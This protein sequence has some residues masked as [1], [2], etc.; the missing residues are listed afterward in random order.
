MAYLHDDMSW[1]GKFIHR[2]SF[3]NKYLNKMQKEKKTIFSIMM[4]HI[5]QLYVCVHQMD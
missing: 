2:N 3:K 5:T 1:S 4:C